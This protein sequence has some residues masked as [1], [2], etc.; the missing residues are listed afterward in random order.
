MKDRLHHPYR[1]P[2]VEDYYP[3][4]EIMINS[5]A[6]A[7][8]LSGAGPTIIGFVT[9]LDTEDALIKAK[10]LVYDMTPGILALGTRLAPIPL[11][12]ARTGALVQDNLLFA[13]YAG[14]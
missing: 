7:V 6:D 11:P 12:F 3:V 10:A 5:G 4:K 1:L 14:T 13:D 8:V 9:G 2:V